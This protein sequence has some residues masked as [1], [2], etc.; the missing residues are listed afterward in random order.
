MKTGARGWRWRVNSQV[1]V[2]GL[3]LGTSVCGPSASAQ[4]AVPSKEYR[5]IDYGYS[6]EL[7]PGLKIEVNPPPAPNHG[8]GVHLA[9]GAYAW[10][11]AAGTEAARSLDETVAEETQKL[12]TICSEISN[13]ATMLGPL[14]AAELRMQCPDP[15]AANQFLRRTY[16]VAYYQL[17]K[18]SVGI[19]RRGSE[20]DPEVESVFRAMIRGFRIIDRR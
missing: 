16:V 6:V 18:Y 13:R 4:P 11:D 5:N 7:P 19:D 15:E 1:L 9:V 3:L 20:E 2:C 17:T 8:F 10:T 14:R 12:S